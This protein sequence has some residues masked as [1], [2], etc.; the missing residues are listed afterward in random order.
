MKELVGRLSALDPEASETLKVI[1]Y[2]DRLVDGR[3]SADV[4]L[5]GAAVLSG[6]PIGY[7]KGSD[8]AGRRFGSQGE[9]LHPGPSDDWAFATT[10]AGDVVWL[11]REGPEHANDAMVLERLAIGLSILS[12]RVDT[13]APSRRAV[14]VLVSG[15]TSDAERDE[16][17]H[18]LSLAA[19]A[20]VYALAVPVTAPV[21]AP[22]ASAIVTSRFGTVRAV[23]S[24]EPV[25]GTAPCG[26]GTV[27]RSPADVHAS[28]R[29][30]LVAL[31]L[32]H[33]GCTVVD[34]AELGPLLVLAEIED[35]RAEPHPDV[36]VV[37]TL[38]AGH[39]TLPLLRALADGESQRSLAA[40]AGVH[41]STL[42]ARLQDLPG[43][44]GFDPLTPSGRT[45]LDVALM[46][47][48]LATTRFD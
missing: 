38:A 34:A 14:E 19:H 12:T 24:R 40:R 1:A 42:G 31:R 47:H 7:R 41:H 5:R 44:L 16:A 39:W 22:A 45:R 30:A 25:R 4:M 20:G 26:I 29:S 2:F 35:E 15:D 36:A 37:E 33:A 32:A 48:R 23:L 28:W 43:S 17:A 21:R 6:A 27:A 10:G 18:R 13:S 9:D 11:E 8:A 3:V 46:L